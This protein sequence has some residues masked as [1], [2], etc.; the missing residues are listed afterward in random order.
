MKTLLTT[1][2]GILLLATATPTY[3]Q[4]RGGTLERVLER[5][6]S[7]EQQSTT[8]P[9]TPTTTPATTTPPTEP[10]E[11]TPVPDPEPTPEIDPAPEE[12]EEEPIP[13]PSTPPESSGGASADPEVLAAQHSSPTAGAGNV[14]RGNALSVDTTYALLTIAFV[15]GIVGL[16]LGAPRRRAPEFIPQTLTSA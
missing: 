14:Y 10:S 3:A 7:Q 15:C 9:V 5:V 6:I 16:M 13:L 2:L 8:T 11:E 4:S 12:E 1:L